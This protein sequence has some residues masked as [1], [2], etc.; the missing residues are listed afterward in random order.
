MTLQT[1]NE[2]IE[3]RTTHHAVRRYWGLLLLLACL[4]AAPGWFAYLLYTHPL[5]R[6]GV[7]TTNKGVLIQKPYRLQSWPSNAKWRLV[8]WYPFPCHK[9]CKRQLDQLARI[10]V[11]LGRRLYEVD[12]VLLQTDSVRTI[13][14]DVISFLQANG[15]ERLLL[16]DATMAAFSERYP[17]AQ[18]FIANP[19]G[20]LVLLYPFKTKPDDVFHDIKQLLSIKG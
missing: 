10:R 20:E 7:A 2:T 15:L 18:W 6:A 8:L 14:S 16:S 19:A 1:S 13:S 11:A 12:G 9:S 5:W 17:A 4:F 3:K